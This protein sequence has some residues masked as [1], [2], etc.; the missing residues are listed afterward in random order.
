MFGQF[1]KCPMLLCTLVAGHVQ[2]PEMRRAKLPCP[3]SG[4]GGCRR[5]LRLQVWAPG[6]PRQARCTRPVATLRRR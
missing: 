6:S 4:I 2:V 5:P 3:A 1:R